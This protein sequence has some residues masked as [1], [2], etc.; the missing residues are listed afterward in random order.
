MFAGLALIPSLSEG[1]FPLGYDKNDAED[2][3]LLISSMRRYV[4]TIP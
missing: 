1:V 3:Q 2:E 4:Y